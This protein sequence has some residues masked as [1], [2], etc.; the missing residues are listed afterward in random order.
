MSGPKIDHAELERQRKAEL[1]RQRQEK[2]RK[3]R[4]ETLILN[5][6]ISK[7]EKQ[8]DTITGHLNLELR[9]AGNADELLTVTGG[10]KALKEKYIK[11]LENALCLNVPS[12]PEAINECSKKLANLTDSVITGYF[13]ESKKFE[14]PIK[15]YIKHLEIQKKLVSIDFSGEAEKIKSIEDFDFTMKLEAINSSDKIEINVK[16]RA[17]AILKEIETLLNSE[18]I[19]ASDFKFLSAIT[20][21]IYK[22]AFETGNG[23]KAAEIEYNTIKPDI[24][25]NIE[26]FDELYQD[27]Y[28]EY[29]VYSE[30][31]NKNKTTLSIV[32]PKEKHK[33][34]SL[35]Q[36]QHEKETLARQSRI[37]TEKNFIRE[38]IDEVMK[39]FGYN[40]SKEIIFGGNLKGS[41]YLCNDKSGSSAIHIHLSDE[42]QI[43]MEIVAVESSNTEILN[44]DLNN[45][46][47]L[48]AA[49]L[50]D[51]ENNNLLSQMGNF[52]AL[53]PKIVDELN[54]RGVV[55]NMKSR[56]E[57]D[58]KYC[59]KIFITDTADKAASFQN[60]LINKDT[61]YQRRLKGKKLAE[62]TLF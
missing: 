16:E 57:P 45:G 58:I 25:K 22:T 61:Q 35:E 27:Y 37:L 24:I 26:I 40:V 33:F 53:H 4:E 13:N 54:K 52:C 49:D 59:K 62:R 47:M 8:I 6:Q 50:N 23:F 44:N 39:E 36:L 15:E 60:S 10:L 32:L 31:L 17:S 46:Q 19:Q 11:R 18:S 42:K 7:T 43:M 21:S 3:I 2:L 20:N 28:A 5:Q 51:N 1:E 48:T 9:K 29:I 14:D 30:L 34:D 12:E 55:F 56:K 38:Q 41:H